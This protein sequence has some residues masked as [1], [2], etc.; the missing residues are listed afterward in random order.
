MRGAVQVEKPS[1][2]EVVVDKTVANPFT[3]HYAFERYL[4][5]GKHLLQKGD[6]AEGGVFAQ[7]GDSAEMVP[8]RQKFFL[9]KSVSRFKPNRELLEHWVSCLW[10]K[11]FIILPRTGCRI[12]LIQPNTK[13]PG[14]TFA[15]PQKPRGKHP[16][17]DGLSYA[18]IVLLRYGN[19]PRQEHDEASHL[20]GHGRCCN[21]EHLVW[22]GLGENSRR[23]ECHHYG[24]ECTCTPRCIPLFKEDRVLINQAIA[25]EKK[26]KKKNSPSTSSVK[27]G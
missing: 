21:P 10:K 23:N 9:H 2:E 12:S 16:Y 1:K 20:C 22:E 18:A 27:G 15:N 11:P 5:C 7:A 14:R 19:F 24:S 4:K 3:S 26:R 25:Q 17:N 6:Q 13:R 8:D